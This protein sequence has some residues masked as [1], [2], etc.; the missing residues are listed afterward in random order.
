MN[1]IEVHL[2]YIHVHVHMYT[3]VHVHALQQLIESI[4]TIHDCMV[5]IMFL[6]VLF[7]TFH[8]GICK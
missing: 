3:C 4:D 1:L 7:Y 2:T 5:C 8:F 6:S